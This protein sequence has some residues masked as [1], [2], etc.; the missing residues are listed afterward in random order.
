M[1]YRKIDYTE[2]DIERGLRAVVTCNGNCNRASKLLNARGTPIGRQVLRMWMVRDHP[3]RYEQIRSE[4]IPQVQA[5]MAEEHMELAK[6]EM[7]V[8]RKLSERLRENADDIEV[9]NLPAASKAMSVS[10][11]VHTDKA[12]ELNERPTVRVEFDVTGILKELRTLG[13]DFGRE[14]AQEL[15]AETLPALP[16]GK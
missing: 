8:S 4:L 13:V 11:A 7:D 16:A 3:E 6:L 1:A 10:A 14:V 5:A 9:K 12:R 15:Q 2:F